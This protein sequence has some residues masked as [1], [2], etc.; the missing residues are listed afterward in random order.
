MG[1]QNVLECIALSFVSDF[2]GQLDIAAILCLVTAVIAT[3]PGCK[4]SEFLCGNGKCITL[5]RV[6]NNVNDCGDSSDEPRYCTRKSCEKND[7]PQ[8][9]PT[10][11]NLTLMPQLINEHCKLI[12]CEIPA[13][14]YSGKRNNLRVRVIIGK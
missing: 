7:S 9:L 11:A 8:K 14:N 3:A 5:N 6:C 2:S 12:I 13:I 10:D 4:V 1:F